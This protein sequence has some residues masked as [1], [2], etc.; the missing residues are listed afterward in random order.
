MSLSTIYRHF[1]IIFFFFFQGVAA[2]LS[3]INTKS[4][5]QGFLGD[6]KDPSKDQLPQALEGAELV[7]ITAGIIAACVASYLLCMKCRDLSRD[8]Y[9]HASL[10]RPSTTSGIARKP[11]MSRDDLFNINAGI[12]ANLAVGVAKVCPKAFILVVTNPVNSTV[13]IVSEVL[14]GIA[15]M[16]CM[17][18]Q[19]Q[20]YHFTESANFT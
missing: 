11:G 10:R 12:I 5:V 18:L 2:D 14:K 9:M 16:L 15:S 17:S 13:P 4:T 19:C 6:T 7:V 8:T 3:H 1:I 20:C